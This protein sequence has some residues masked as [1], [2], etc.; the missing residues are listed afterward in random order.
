MSISKD[1]EEP[2]P[3]VITLELHDVMREIEANGELP[4]GFVLVY[5]LADP[6]ESED[7]SQTD[8]FFRAFA[9]SRQ[10]IHKKTVLMYQDLPITRHEL[11]WFGDWAKMQNMIE[12]SEGEVKNNLL[13]FLED[14]TLRVM[15]RMDFM[16]VNLPQEEETVAEEDDVF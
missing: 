10:M 16:F 11:A 8:F 4:D 13:K 5:M 1:N 12:S 15:P 3:E 9:E 7:G 14:E 2:E 6:E